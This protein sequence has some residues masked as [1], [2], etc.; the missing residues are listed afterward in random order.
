MLDTIALVSET[1]TT[2][3]LWCKRIDAS[4]AEATFWMDWDAQ[5]MQFINGA[6]P[7]DKFESASVFAHRF[8]E[9][10]TWNSTIG[11][12]AI[13]ERTT[14]VFQGWVVVRPD[15]FFEGELNLGY[16]LRSQAWGRGYA[17]EAAR[18]MI[19]RVARAGSSRLI[20][21]TLDRHRASLHILNKL[22]FQHDFDF[23]Y[24]AK[25]LPKWSEEE[26]KGKRYSLSL[27]M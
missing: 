10:A 21:H 8:Q 3:R 26:R 19:H 27:E 1:F 15:R 24:P 2:K 12:F 9:Q 13:H 16:R 20:A 25:A 4:Y 14:G 11:F 7:T 23:V 18:A 6:E 17:T 22:G 5:V